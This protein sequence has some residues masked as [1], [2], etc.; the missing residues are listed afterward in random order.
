MSVI[1]RVLFL[2]GMGTFLLFGALHKLVGSGCAWGVLGVVGLIYVCAG[3]VAL[4]ERPS[5]TP[6][7][8]VTWQHRG[9]VIALAHRMQRAERL[10]WDYNPRPPA[11]PMPTGGIDRME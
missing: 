1:D 9:S 11:T 6:R 4:V 3:V 2:G 10:T 7:K 5:S 8:V